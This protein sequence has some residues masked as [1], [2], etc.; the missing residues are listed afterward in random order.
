MF[1]MSFCTPL[2]SITLY[3]ENNSIVSLDWGQTPEN[4]ETILLLEARNQIQAYFRGELKNFDIPVAPKGTD[5]QK[6]TWNAIKK[7]P[8]GKTCF[9]SNIAKEIN[10]FA[11]S[12]GQ[13]CA[14]NPIPIIIPCHRILSKNSNKEYYSFFNG[15]ESKR[16]LLNLEQF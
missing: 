2:G 16:H 12:V 1:Q 4:N 6:I 14:K 11:R 3:E 5:L 10:S 7:I 8:Y 15:I 9:Y 13:A